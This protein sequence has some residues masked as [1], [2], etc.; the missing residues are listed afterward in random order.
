MTP[1]RTPLIG[2]LLLS[3]LACSCGRSPGV[4]GEELAHQIDGGEAPLVLD[5]RSK[6]E[7]ASGHVPGAIHMPFRSVGDRHGELPVE[8]DDPIVVYCAHGPRAVWAAKSLRDAGY[9]N[10]VYLEGHMSSWSKAGL[11]TETPPAAS[12]DSRPE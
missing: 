2:L 1:N 4:T 7:Y 9:T 12:G 8:K 6:S 3:L 11:P 5:V 10:V